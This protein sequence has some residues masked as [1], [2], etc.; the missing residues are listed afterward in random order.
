[1]RT[2]SIP[3]V[4]PTAGTFEPEVRQ[5]RIVAAA[6]AERKTDVGDVALEDEARVVVQIA[7]Q[8]EVDVD[9]S[10][11][12]E[13]ARAIEQLIEPV[14]RRDRLRRAAHGARRQDDFAAAALHRE[15]HQLVLSQGAQADDVALLDER[16]GRERGIGSQFQRLEDAVDDRR[17]VDI[18]PRVAQPDVVERLDRHEERLGIGVD[19][20]RPDQLDAGLGQLAH[21]AFL[22]LVVVAEDR[23][24]IG[25]PQRQ[26]HVAHP[27]RD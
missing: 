18:E 9:A 5:E 21:A 3:A 17:V 1:M 14:E 25:Q 11:V 23:R 19:A 6:A 10:L 2:R 20:G 7:Q 12:A 16:L 4:Q 27:R 13:R 24:D 15:I 8:R 22:R 26:R